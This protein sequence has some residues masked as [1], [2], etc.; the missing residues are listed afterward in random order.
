MNA[1]ALARELGAKRVGAEWRTHCLAHEDTT[2]SL[3]F[4]D[5]DRS[6]LFMCRAGCD[7]A[8]VVAA[9][10]SKFPDVFN[11]TSR[12]ADGDE[13]TYEVR[14][15]RGVLVAVHARY[16]RPDGTKAFAWRRD[17]TS[18][19]GGL[20]VS[21]L[22][23]FGAELLG[24]LH[25]PRGEPLIVCEGEKAAIAA[26]R[27]WPCAL[28]TVT[29]ASSAPTAKALSILAGHRVVLWPDSI[30]RAVRTWKGCATGW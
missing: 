11:G 1:E 13:A 22:P 17:G 2:P 5:G 20:S 18:G 7:Q 25:H 16:R 8:T 4:K 9:M 28:G 14:N 24:K 12:A 30:H 3:D 21:N 19:L 23:L 6:I 26:R 15:E 27:V 29:G 10:K